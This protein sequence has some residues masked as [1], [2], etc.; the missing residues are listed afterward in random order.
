MKTLILVRHA[1]SSWKDAGPDHDRPL[2]KRGTRDAP[3]MGRRMAK[4]GVTPELII[5][6]TAARAVAT[7]QAIAE[8]VGYPRERIVENDRLYGAGPLDWVEIIRGVTDR[9]RRTMVVGHNPTIT[10][11]ANRL[12]GSPVDNIPTCGV[13]TLEYGVDCWKDIVGLRPATSHVDYP[14][15]SV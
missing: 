14:K 13:V 12:M 4:R 3:E 7:A 6:S 10:E 1:K 5:T 8:A 11:V 9:V 15:K 2:N